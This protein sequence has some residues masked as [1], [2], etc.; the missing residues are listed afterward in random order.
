MNVMTTTPIAF[1]AT[2]VLKLSRDLKKMTATLTRNGARFLVDDY[3]QLQQHRI[4]LESQVRAAQDAGEPYELMSFLADN[5]GKLERNVKSALGVYSQANPVGRWA[6]SIIGIGPVISAGLLAHLDITRSASASHIWS[7]AGLTPDSKK[8]RGK[9]LNYN[10]ALKVLAWKI[11]E[12]FVKQS[13][14]AKDFYGHLYLK[15]KEYE[16]AKNLKGDYADQA[17]AILKEKNFSDDTTAKAC[18]EKGQLPPGHIHARAKR[19]AVKMFLSHWWFVA[20]SLHYQKTPPMPYPIEHGGH[21][22]FLMPP[23][24]P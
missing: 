14:N 10:P 21:V 19:Y 3:Y 17:A 20:Y 22:D 2:S 11:G 23:N 4:R 7:Y 9:K 24:F 18:Y 15:R 16:Q 12:S 6:E 13:G 8:V 5:L 1:D